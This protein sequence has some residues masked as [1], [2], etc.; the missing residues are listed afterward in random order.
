MHS[1]KYLSFS[2]SKVSLL[3]L[4]DLQNMEFH[5]LVRLLHPFFF[6]LA[7]SALLVKPVTDSGKDDIIVYFPGKDTQVFSENYFP[8][9]VVV[10]V[11]LLMLS[12]FSL[13]SI[14]LFF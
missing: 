3:F 6:F 9:F 4:Y 13:S 7:G 10:V 5:D 14:F 2:Y 12:C 8:V 1:L 11:L